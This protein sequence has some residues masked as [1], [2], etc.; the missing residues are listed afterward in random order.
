MRAEYRGGMDITTNGKNFIG[1]QS[2]RTRA[3]WAGALREL[4]ENRLIERR[5]DARNV[6]MLTR[7]GYEMAE[8]FKHAIS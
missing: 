1:D 2:A 8:K 3:L 4:E 5:P 7:K 6:F